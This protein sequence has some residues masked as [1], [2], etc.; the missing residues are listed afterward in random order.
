VAYYRF[1]SKNIF[2]AVG[3]ISRVCGEGKMNGI[4]VHDLE[5]TKN[6]LKKKD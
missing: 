6:K 3:K 5:F 4:G 1:Y 2:S